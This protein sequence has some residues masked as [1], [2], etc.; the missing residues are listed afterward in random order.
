M[1]NLIEYIDEFDPLSELENDDLF[2]RNWQKWANEHE[3]WSFEDL[4]N[5]ANEYYQK[6][7]LN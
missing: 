3:R 5:Y 7:K 2:Y 6:M 4:Q 1:D